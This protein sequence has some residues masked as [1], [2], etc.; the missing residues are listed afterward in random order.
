MIEPTLP[1]SP[2]RFLS[3][4]RRGLGLILLVCAGSLAGA[5]S[6]QTYTVRGGDTLFGVAKKAGISVAALQKLNKLSGTVLRPGQVLRLR[7]SA[8]RP[9]ARTTVKLPPLPPA[10]PRPSSSQISGPKKWGTPPP[11]TVTSFIGWALPGADSPFGN[12]LP[13]RTYLP[14]LGFSLQTHNNCGPSAL[15]SV[16]GFY[17][18]HI[19][20]NVIQRTA[21]PDGGYMQISAIAPE[22]RKF[23]LR[24]L[25]VRGGQLSQV[26]RLLALGIPVI[27]LQWYGPSGQIPHFRVVRGYDDQAGLVWVSDSM[28]GPLAYM[29]YKSFDALWNTQSR[30]MFPVYPEGYDKLVRR[31]VGQG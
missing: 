22:L 28:V 23:K 19:G 7:A 6:T 30:Q 26:K 17:R 3:G 5:A 4:L 18:V 31:L 27:V 15:S 11:A 12:E 24:T 10:T 1:A 25:S 13:L 20:Q 14:G 2:S 29:S 16:L 9:V 8:V 21:R